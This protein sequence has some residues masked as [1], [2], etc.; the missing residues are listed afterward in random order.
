MK[1][2]ELSWVDWLLIGIGLFLL[3]HMPILIQMHRS[4]ESYEGILSTVGGRP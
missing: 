1:D 2:S 3:F 4:A